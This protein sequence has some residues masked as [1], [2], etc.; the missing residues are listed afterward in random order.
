MQDN[1]SDGHHSKDSKDN[2]KQENSNSFNI[3]RGEGESLL[4]Y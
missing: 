3:I 2:E 1:L 4:A